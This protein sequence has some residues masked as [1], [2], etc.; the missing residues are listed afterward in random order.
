MARSRETSVT[1]LTMARRDVDCVLRVA[2]ADLIDV[3]LSC[4][5]L[6]IVLNTADRVMRV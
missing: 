3:V 1:P 2:I 4:L 5:V 6:T